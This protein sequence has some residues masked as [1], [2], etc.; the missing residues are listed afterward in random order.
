MKTLISD[1]VYGK[2]ESESREKERIRIV[3]LIGGR[4]RGENWTNDGDAVAI[5]GC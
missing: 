2:I 4:R 5:V 3:A 1:Y